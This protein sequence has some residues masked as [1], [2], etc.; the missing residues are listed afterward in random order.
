MAMLTPSISKSDPK[1]AAA[2]RVQDSC[3]EKW[4]TA[5]GI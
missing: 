4:T 1:P 3:E 5:T 2:T